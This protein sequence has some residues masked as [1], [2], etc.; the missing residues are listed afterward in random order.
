[1]NRLLGAIAAV[2]ASDHVSLVDVA[3]G[4]DL[5]TA[6]VVETP[7]TAPYLEA[8]RPVWLLFKETEVSLAKQ[9]SGDI[10]LSNRI[11]A[12]VRAVRHGGL[13][14]EVQLDY[15]GQPLVSVITTRS[16]ERLKLRPGDRVEGLVKSNEMMLMDAADAV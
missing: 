12:T 16:A 10:S 1:M 6:A 3:V 7:V 2:A 11:P 14:S 4:E 13:L 9:L 8:G 15:R 5:F